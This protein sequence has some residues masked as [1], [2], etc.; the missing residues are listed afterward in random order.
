MVKKYTKKSN[1]D[2]DKEVNELIEKAN[3][4]IENS[5]TTP[6]NL[7]ELLNFQE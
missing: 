5:F 4:G 3:I 7:K 6:E 2:K 1:A